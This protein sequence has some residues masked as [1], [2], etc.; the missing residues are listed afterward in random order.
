MGIARTRTIALFGTEGV[1]VDIE[2]SI[3]NGAPGLHL[4]GLPD[5]TVSETRD[6]VRAAI[7]NSDQNWPNRHVVVSLYPA[8]LPKRGSSFDLAIAIATLAATNSVPAQACADMVLIGELGLDGRVRPVPGVLPVVLSAAETGAA[9]VI[10]PQANAPEASLV[11]GVEVIAVASLRA[12]VAHLRGLPPPPDGEE[13]T[14]DGAVH[15][16][17]AIR[18][19]ADLDLADVHGQ[20]GG[21]KAVEVAAAGGHHLA[22][23]GPLGA[24]A[25]MLAERLPNL[26][27][28][29]GQDDALEVTA[30]HS[31]AGTLHAD[32]PLMTRP[33]YC[34]PH[35]SSSP[36]AVLGGGTNRGIR[37][38][39]VSLAHRGVLYLDDAAE[40]AVRTLEAL[41]QPLEDGTVTIS[42]GGLTA[43]FPARPIAVLA[44][45][46]CPCGAR[47]PHDC[48]CPPAVRQHYLA[49]LPRRLLDR[50]PI[51]Q[52]L[53]PATQAELRS[54]LA[55]AE[56]SQRV[57]ERVHAARER[58]ARR[59]ANTP[60]RTNAEVPGPQLRRR[61]A[62]SQ[63]AI[64]VL[65][66]PLA[67]GRLSA[68][69]LDQVIRLAW[70]L[71]DLDGSDAPT[72]EDIA[73]ALRLWDGVDEPPGG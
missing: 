53:I 39:A 46:P 12:L 72:G 10:V 34:A 18:P 59:L 38:G 16:D 52:R 36:A 37:P 4:I 70:T 25:T 65:D 29:L 55:S 68:R 9:A 22:L 49:R 42:R 31:V 8:S 41:V 51:K 58:V 73:M 15:R 6:R 7:I 57:A 71:A 21:R 1:V 54:D 48:T 44:A 43:T 28:D 5:T 66:A 32:Q 3:T 40:F 62:P 24:G 35:H 56:S 47:T 69:G 13:G 60:W 30:I 27:P 17:H 14:A 50:I 23:L 63:G 61:F 20:P 67:D 45:H 19:R 64:D 11:P 2:A 26:L 33:P